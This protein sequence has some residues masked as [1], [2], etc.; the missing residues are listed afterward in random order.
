MAWT[1]PYVQEK[2]QQLI[3]HIVDFRGYL[4]G[5]T[6]AQPDLQKLKEA[7]EVAIDT[8][9]AAKMP[10]QADVV[11]TTL[12][13]GICQTVGSLIATKTGGENFHQY[14]TKVIAII[15]AL[16]KF[17]EAC[18]EEIRNRVKM[19][20]EQEVFGIYDTNQELNMLVQHVGVIVKKMETLLNTNAEGNI[21]KLADWKNFFENY[22][23]EAL[24]NSVNL[25]K[26]L[27]D[28]LNSVINSINDIER[29]KK[30]AQIKNQQLEIALN[31]QEKNESKFTKGKDALLKDIE[32]FHTVPTKPFSWTS[33]FKRGVKHSPVLSAI[34]YNMTSA[35]VSFGVLSGL[36]E[37]VGDLFNQAVHAD[38]SQLGFKS[39]LTAGFLVLGVSIGG[40]VLYAH[41]RP[42]PK[43]EVDEAQIPLMR[44]SIRSSM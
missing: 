35:G 32:D 33:L 27:N 23:H 4:A 25:G 14:V 13:N 17:N 19:E 21:K 24:K 18:S 41:H 5:K 20:K 3:A 31:I 10:A 44:N 37:L 7:L 36:N 40:A 9:F 42:E 6:Q 8:V 2:L 38:E 22:P 11:M 28:C 30:G 12:I 26:D 34:A 43:E 29:K 15:T 39:Y 16:L 1:S